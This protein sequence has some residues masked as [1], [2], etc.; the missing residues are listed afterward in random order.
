MRF[1]AFKSDNNISP[2][3]R[4]AHLTGEHTWTSLVK[5]LGAETKAKRY[6]LKESHASCAVIPAP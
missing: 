4:G 5:M 6:G 2:T 1:R 3:D